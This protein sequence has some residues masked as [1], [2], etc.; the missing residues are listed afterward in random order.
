MYSVKIASPEDWLYYP[1]DERYTL[2][3]I[4]LKLALND[5]GTLEF[6]IYQNNPHFD[7]LEVR[8]TMLLFYR[9]DDLLFS[10]EVRELQADMSGKRHIYCVGELSFLYDTVQ[11]QAEFHDYSVSSFV[12]RIITRHN[13][14]AALD[15]A[16]ARKIMTPGEI[17]VTDSNDALFRYTNYETTHDVLIKKVAEPLEGYIRTRRISDSLCYLDVLKLED[18]GKHAEQEI[19]LGENLLDFSQ[20][21]NSDNIIT[22]LIPL[23]KKKDDIERTDADIKAL[24]AY[25]DI[26]QVNDGK[27]YLY[28]PQAVL[29]FGWVCAVKQWEDVFIPYNLKRKGQAYLESGQYASLSLSM[30]AID[31]SLLN[32]SFDSFA[33]GDMVHVLAEPYGLDRWFPVTEME[34]RPLQPENSR[35]TLGSSDATLTKLTTN[36]GGLRTPTE[37][38]IVEYTQDPMFSNFVTNRKYSTFESDDASEYELQ[39][40]KLVT[41]WQGAPSGFQDYIQGEVPPSTYSMTYIVTDIHGQLCCFQPELGVYQEYF[42]HFGNVWHKFMLFDNTATQTGNI[43]SAM[44]KPGTYTYKLKLTD[45]HHYLYPGGINPVISTAN[46]TEYLYR[47]W[48]I[49]AGFPDMERKLFLPFLTAPEKENPTDAVVSVIANRRLK[50]RRWHPSTL[51]AAKYVTKTDEGLQLESGGVVC[52]RIPVSDDIYNAYV[53]IDI[54]KITDA[55]GTDDFHIQ[56]NDLDGYREILSIEADDMS[57]DFQTVTI[58]AGEIKRKGTTIA[59]SYFEIYLGCYVSSVVISNFHF[60]GDRNTYEHTDYKDTWGW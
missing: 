22:A 32:S 31:L 58:P 47:Q 12:N 52:I 54:K 55:A 29:N 2:A 33:L 11:P 7:D 53:Q 59:K 26:R 14:Q 56:I 50:T 28:L 40:V 18:Y 1:G 23:G 6:D 10:G 30:T 5:A 43:H 37:S 4:V 25:I 3:D 20:S 38:T 46:I 17:T 60:Y 24:E 36:L 41:D 16:N 45:G 34:I 42:E 13:E 9:D 19:R 51:N 57:R 21:L 49:D 35:L 27:N 8:K 48:F 44:E 15:A 39:Q